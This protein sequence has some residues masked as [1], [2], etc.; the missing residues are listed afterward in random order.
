MPRRE[1]QIEI[2][3]AVLVPLHSLAVGGDLG[4]I[5]AGLKRATVAG[6]DDDADLGIAIARSKR[7]EFV[8]PSRSSVLGSV[9]C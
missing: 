7:R 2:E 5:D 6:V 1:M 9:D 4:D 3:D 8:A